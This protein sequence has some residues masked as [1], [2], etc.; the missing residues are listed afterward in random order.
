MSA[1]DEKLKQGMAAVK[2]GRKKEARDILFDVLEQDEENEQ[3][4]LWM[5][6]AVET[7]QQR[8]TCLEKVLHLN[9]ENEAAKRG[10]ASLARSNTALPSRGEAHQSSGGPQERE[11]MAAGLDCAPSSARPPARWPAPC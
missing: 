4:W 5:S 9:P 1:V 3:A 10:I 6:G 7:D 11:Q 8:R 2:A